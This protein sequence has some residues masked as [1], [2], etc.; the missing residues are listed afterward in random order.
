MTDQVRVILHGTPAA[1][2][3]P[4]FTRNGRTYTD[5]KTKAAE[6]ALLAA[7]LVEAAGRPA[8]DGPV[9][10]HVRATFPVPESWPKWRRKLAQLGR[11]AHTTKPDLDNLVKTLDAL[12]GHAWRDDAQ[13]DHICATKGY[14]VYP[15]TEL[16]IT[17]HPKP[18]K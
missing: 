10:V 15:C 9:S 3:R 16:L 18:S 7:Y 8:H 14:G 12:N 5:A 1:K 17:F 11:W 13:I 4:R 6:G 2:A